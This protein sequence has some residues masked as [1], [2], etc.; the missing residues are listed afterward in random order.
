LTKREDFIFTIGYSGNSAIVDSSLKKKFG[1][2]DSEALAKKGLFKAALCSAIFANR[3]SELDKVLA[4]YNSKAEGAI[5][6]SE[7]LKRKFGVFEVPAGITKV[8]RI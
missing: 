1:L 8:I 7:D 3:E 6:S 5:K 2:L 4:I